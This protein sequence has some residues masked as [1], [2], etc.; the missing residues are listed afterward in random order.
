MSGFGNHFLISLG[1]PATYTAPGGLPMPCRAIV[2]DVDS[3]ADLTRAAELVSADA[4]AS[5]SDALNPSRGGI[6]SV[7][8]N[9]YEV[10]GKLR[11]LVPGLV[12]LGLIRIS[13][14]GFD[15]WDISRAAL[16]V[17][18]EDIEILDTPDAAPRTV[19]AVVNRSGVMVSADEFGNEIEKRQNTIAI[20]AESVGAL[21]SRSIL[22]FDGQDHSIDQAKTRLG[23]GMFRVVC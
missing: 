8:G 7:D 1:R 17:W 21:T 6:L 15:A 12:D 9:E 19:R 23:V 2:K 14:D 16:A 11:A 20:P 10:S 3:L 4:V 13:G 18:G 22:R 5:V